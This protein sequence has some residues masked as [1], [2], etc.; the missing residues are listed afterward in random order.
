MLLE[1][2]KSKE[3]LEKYSIKIADAQIFCDSQLATIFAEKI[4]YPVAMKVWGDNILHRSDI[5][6]VLLN[7][8]DSEELKTQFP[9]IQK[10]SP[11]IIVQKMAQGQSVI[12]G[13]KQD[14]QFGP[15]IMFG[16]GG[17]FVEV[18]KDVSFRLCPITLEEAQLM[19]KE[20]KG[21]PILAGI[22]GQKPINL[23]A[24]SAIIVN[25]SKLAYENPQIKEIDLNPVLVDEN[26][27]IAA[28]FKFL[29]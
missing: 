3:L 14:P 13:I 28:D 15:V 8:R 7:I 5:G 29:I 17:I 21:Y 12:I 10:I 2:N 11:Q 26:G 20:I 4:G 6:G 24:L 9:K 27:A 18:L 19:V 25:I 23:S 16:L 1:F 22:R